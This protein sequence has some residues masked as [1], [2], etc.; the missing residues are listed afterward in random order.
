[1]GCAHS[2][3]TQ[4]NNDLS[5]IDVGQLNQISDTAKLQEEKR[6]ERNLNKIKDNIKKR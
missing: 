3:D 2:S 6:I 5:K 1:M 4:E